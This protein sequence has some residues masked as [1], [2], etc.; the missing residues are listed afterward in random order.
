MIDKIDQVKEE[1]MATGCTLKEAEKLISDYRK[2][3][4]KG[5]RLRI[6]RKL[7]GVKE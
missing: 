1:L 5:K 6:L 2:D 4:D 3:I 7:K